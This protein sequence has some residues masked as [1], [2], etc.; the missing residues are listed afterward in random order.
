MIVYS[1][2]ISSS[3]RIVGGIGSESIVG[4]CCSEGIGTVDGFEMTSNLSFCVMLVSDAGCEG[5]MVGVRAEDV[6]VVPAAV[7]PSCSES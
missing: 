1:L 7:S 2:I 5:V 4:W 3:V 6:M